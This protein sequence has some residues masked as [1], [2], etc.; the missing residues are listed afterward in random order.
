[1]SLRSSRSTLPR[2][3]RSFWASVAS[4]FKTSSRHACSRNFRA[5]RSLAISFF[6]WVIWSREMAWSL[7]MASSRAATPPITFSPIAA[8]LAATST[9]RTAIVV[10]ASRKTASRCAASSSLIF[11]LRSVAASLASAAAMPDLALKVTSASRPSSLDRKSV[12]RAWASC[13][14]FAMASSLCS[15]A[16][17]RATSSSSN[18][19]LAS[20]SAAAFSASRR[21]ASS[22]AAFLPFL[23][24]LGMLVLRGL[25]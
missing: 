23:P 25:V 13:S 12:S 20:R 16:C 14:R 22:A 5:S 6:L 1:M 18:F 24:F 7:S 4:I 17:S 8:S 2:A 15:N 10:S 11:A 21:A 19:L 9:S 3:S